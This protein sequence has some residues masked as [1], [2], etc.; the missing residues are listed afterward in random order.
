MV[1]E[2]APPERDRLRFARAFTE[3]ITSFGVAAVT[4]EIAPELDSIMIQAM[5]GEIDGLLAAANMRA[6]SV[7]AEL[8]RSM[9]AAGARLLTPLV[10]AIDRLDFPQARAEVTPLLGAFDRTPVNRSLN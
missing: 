4:P 2:R 9:N 7:C 6:V 1:W 3:I 5:L 8:G 10:Q